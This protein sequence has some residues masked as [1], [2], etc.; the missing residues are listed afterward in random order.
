MAMASLSP[1]DY[2]FHNPSV[3]RA[4]LGRVERLWSQVRG[5]FAYPRCGAPLFLARRRA[6]PTNWRPTRHSAST[7][8]AIRHDF[9]VNSVERR[10]V[11]RVRRLYG[12]PGDVGGG[13]D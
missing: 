2:R 5:N 1:A 7:S 3:P 12:Q 13:W 8:G 6:I 9:G 10:V 11:A 4:P